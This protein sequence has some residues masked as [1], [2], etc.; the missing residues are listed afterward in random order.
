MIKCNC[1]DKD[2]SDVLI[3]ELSQVIEKHRKIAKNLRSRDSRFD[4]VVSYYDRT[5][6]VL[7]EVVGEI[8]KL[9][10]C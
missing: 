9:P 4:T 6:T 7:E 8:K 1:I 2:T 5:A 10:E 3:V